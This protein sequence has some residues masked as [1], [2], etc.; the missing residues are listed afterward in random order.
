MNKKM[1][2]NIIISVVSL[3]VL[4]G[5]YYFVMNMPEKETKDDIP[6][7]TPTPTIEVLSIKS[8]EISEI[9]IK[10]EDNS[11]TVAKKEENEFYVKEY[12]DYRFSNAKLNSVFYDFATVNAEKEMT[13]DDDY[14]FLESVN[15]TEILLNDGTIHSLTLGNK[16]SGS[17]SYFLKY[18]EKAYVVSQYEG[19]SF[20]KTVN[21]LRETNIMAVDLQSIS[22]FSV[23]KDGKNFIDIR[24]IKEEERDS[25]SM[26]TS[27][28]MTNPKYISVSMDGYSAIMQ[29]MTDITAVDFPLDNDPKKYGIGR[30]T[31]KFT[32]G[33]E[34][35]KILYGDKDEKGNVYAQIEGE[36]YVFLTSP[37]FFDELSTLDPQALMDKFSLLVSIDNITGVEIFGGGKN[38]NFVINGEGDDAKY[39]INNKEM[40]DEFFK[41]AYQ[42]VIGLTT[43]GLREMDSVGGVEYTVIYKYKNGNQDICEYKNYDERNYAVFINDESEFIILKK[44]L[45]SAMTA[46]EGF[47]KQ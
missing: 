1:L 42:E 45:T 3:A 19:S 44:K 10:N 27:H 46:I 33:E 26:V 47:M 5:A 6:D 30:L 24:E 40:K 32:A 4:F 17:N 37:T 12:P 15:T 38:Y 43:N 31:F 23:D 11:F 7:Y 22:A 35:H 21:S 16:V 36:S 14:G 8:D 2:R 13:E 25:F 9:S 39:F 41:K 34:T 20:L 18:N 29:K 28:V